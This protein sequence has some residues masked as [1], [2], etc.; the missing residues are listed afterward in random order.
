MQSFVEIGSPVLERRYFKV[1]YHIWA[2]R[3]SLSCDLDYL[4]IYLFPLPIDLAL[5]GQVVSEKIFE[6]CVWTTD[7]PRSSDDFD[8]N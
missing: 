3:P 2:W 8:L 5:I 7:R 1:F 6:K 4:Y